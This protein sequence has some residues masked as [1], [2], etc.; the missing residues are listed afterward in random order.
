VQV[1]VE[2]ADRVDLVEEV[3]FFDEKVDLILDGR[4]RENPRTALSASI[5]EEADL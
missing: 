2:D 4:R 3:A 5:V 1:A